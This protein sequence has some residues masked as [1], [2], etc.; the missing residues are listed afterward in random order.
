MA[1]DFN[2]EKRRYV[3]VGIAITVVLLYITRL[4]VLQIMSDDYKKNA[5]SNAFLNKIQYPSRGIIYDR[6]NKLLVYNQPAYDVTVVMKEIEHLDTLDLCQTL[7]ITK[8]YFIKRMADIKD[9][10][11]NPGYSR[12]TNQLFMVQLSAEESS[13]LQEKLFK[14]RGFYVQQRSIRQYS[15]NSA[16]HILGDLGEAS[17]ANIEDDDY[18]VR[19][20]YIGKQGVEKFYEK[21]L[22]GHKGVEILLRDAHGRIQGKYLNGKLDKRPIPGKNLRLSI[23]IEL[24]KFGEKL[25]GSKIGAIVAIEPETGEILCLVS[26]PTFNPADM[27]GRQ[28]GK[29]H[30]AL[31]RDPRKPLFNRALMASYPPGSTFKPAQSLIFLQEK[32]ITPSTS[33]PCYHGFVVPGLRVGCHSHPS[34][35]PLV[36]ALATSC[37]SY[38]CWGLYK[39]IDNKKYLNSDS[40]LTVWKDHMVSMGFGYKLGIDLPGEKRGLIPNAKFYDKIYGKGRW[41]GLRI[42]HTAIGQGE[43]LLT[44]LQIAN[45]GATIANRGH[46][47]TPHVVRSIIGGRLDSTYLYPK[48]TTIDPKYYSYIIKGMRGA[49]EHGTCTRA[50]YMP[51]MEVCGKTGTAQNRGKDH[52]VFMGFAPM[53]KPKIAIC[54]YVENGGWGATYAV[55]IGALMMEHYL[56]GKI[57]PE[58]EKLVESL[59]NAVISYGAQTR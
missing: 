23:D 47:R 20:D 44:P 46:F 17:M 34:P 19:G 48:Y 18:Y 3:I 25:M 38:F 31:E 29:M 11:K 59:S 7:N 52:S 51:E 15:Y 10:S 40:A 45:L 54:V 24:Q 13:V 26:T 39:M 4:F 8:E 55:P 37:N 32:I 5:D 9:R 16:A 6:N 36:P 49:V 43:V 14:F 28:R 12:F 30:M 57:A 56:K 1:R 33:F 27:V 42:I 21:Q 53:S 2:L 41:G 50:N 22:R 35:L 58:R